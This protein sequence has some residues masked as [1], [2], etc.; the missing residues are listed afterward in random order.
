MSAGQGAPTPPVEGR[1]M[2]NVRLNPCK[3]GKPATME[4]TENGEGHWIIF[5]DCCESGIDWKWD[6]LA[7]M[8]NAT[9]SPTTSEGTQK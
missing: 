4:R 1:P 7:R 6:R 8:W 5:T 3:H 9:P 2:P